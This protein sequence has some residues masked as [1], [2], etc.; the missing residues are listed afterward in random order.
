MTPMMRMP[1]LRQVR[2]A[3]E[4]PWWRRALDWFGGAAVYEVVEEFHCSVNLSNGFWTLALPAGFRSDLATTPRLS[5]L[6]GFRPDGRLLIPGLF[7]DFWYRHG[8][9][10]VCGERDELRGVVVGK[11]TA[12]IMFMDLVHETS[13]LHLPG[14]VGF[15]ALT[16][17]GWPAWWASEKY[18]EAARRT[19][20]LQLHGDYT[21]D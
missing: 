8:Q 2:R 6:F 11:W 7:H 19:G 17:F 21:D 1:V 15:I 12:D 4:G 3:P 16:L 9:V 14:L 10:L 5:W 20:K 18:R 13:G